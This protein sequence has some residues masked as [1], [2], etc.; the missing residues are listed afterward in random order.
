MTLGRILVRSAKE[1]NQPKA[2]RLPHEAGLELVSVPRAPKELPVCPL[3]PSAHGIEGWRPFVDWEWDQP[4]ALG[5]TP[6]AEVGRSGDLE[7]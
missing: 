4:S 5:P 6:F 7:T 1:V 3:I 2:D